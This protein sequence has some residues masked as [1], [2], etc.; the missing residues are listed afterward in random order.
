MQHKFVVQ[1]LSVEVGEH[2]KW[3]EYHPQT[4]GQPKYDN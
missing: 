2:E 1:I 4:F 3:K